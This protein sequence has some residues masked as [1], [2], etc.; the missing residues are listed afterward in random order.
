[1][2]CQVFPKF[3][4]Q[5]L[6]H[7]CLLRRCCHTMFA[8]LGVAIAIILA[9]IAEHIILAVSHLHS[10]NKAVIFPAEQ[11]S[12]LTPQTDQ[13]HKIRQLGS[14]GPQVDDFFQ[15]RSNSGAT[16][17][18]VCCWTVQNGSTGGG[19]SWTLFLDITQIGEQQD[20]AFKVS[21]IY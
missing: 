18:A 17:F 21:K 15:L 20:G 12:Q 11:R 3:D 19:S 10:I 14:W 6:H 9:Y 5:K 7:A 4:Q 16:E 2:C 13:S 1:M 8:S